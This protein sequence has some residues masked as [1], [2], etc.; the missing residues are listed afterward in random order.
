MTDGET[1]PAL[2]IT[3]SLGSKGHRIIVGEKAQPSLAQTSRYCH[4]SFTYPDPARDSAGFV[5]TLV[6]RVRERDID[7]V[8]PV[9]EITTALVVE[10]RREIERH[11]RIPFPQAATFNRAAN[12]VEVLALAEKLS[13][14]IPTG[15]VLSRPGE[16]PLWPEGLRFPVVIKPHR[17]RILVNGRWRPTSVTYAESENEL[18][19]ILAAKDPSEYPLLL[20]QRVIGPGVGVF[21]CYQRGKLVAQF[22]HR[23][24]REK[25][26]S[27][28]VSVLSE[29]APVSPQAKRYA[30]ALLDELRWE[31]VAMVEF[32]MDQAS[33]TLKLMEINGRFWGSLQLAIDAGVDFPFLLLQTMAD[34]PMEPVGTYR[35]GVKSRWLMGDFDALLL[36][37]FKRNEELH[38]PPGHAGKLLSILRFMKLWQKDTYN[39]IFRFSDIKPGL[40]EAKRWFSHHD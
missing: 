37:L 22:S 13:I 4:E 31:G 40:Y 10:N 25:P 6:R 29:S 38:L 28:G 2:A 23:R 17:S 15:V 16:R 30:Q 3:R 12:K 36:R 9:T 14:P 5:E 27:G 32:K 33:Q 11:S 21:M 35:I 24:L 26:P 18:N 8:L 20:Q 1:R 19:A 39:E 34:K 7:V